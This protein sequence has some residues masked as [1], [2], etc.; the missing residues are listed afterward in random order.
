MKLTY[1]LFGRLELE[2]E[3]GRDQQWL[4][5]FIRNWPKE[6]HEHIGGHIYGNLDD[7]YSDNKELPIADMFEDDSDHPGEKIVSCIQSV[8]ISPFHL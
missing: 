6:L 2:A 7:M 3:D 4:M 1:G 5:E 8:T